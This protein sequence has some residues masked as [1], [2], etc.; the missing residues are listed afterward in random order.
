MP[1]PI[2]IDSRSR[3]WHRR[4][5]HSSLLAVRRA[6]FGK[7][8]RR[9]ECVG[10]EPVRL[11]LVLRHARI[12]DAVPHVFGRIIDHERRRVRCRRM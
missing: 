1:G 12:D 3:G 9:D 5:R 8:I 10:R 7:G 11:L 4:T 6:N 2:P